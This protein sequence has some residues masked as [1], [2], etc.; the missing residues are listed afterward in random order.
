MFRP[1]RFLENGSRLRGLDIVNCLLFEYNGLVVEMKTP[2]VRQ[3]P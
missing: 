2:A 3:E 1:L